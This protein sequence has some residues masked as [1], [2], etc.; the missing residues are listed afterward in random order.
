MDLGEAYPCLVVAVSRGKI[1][2]KIGEK[3][4]E[5]KE[6]SEEKVGVSEAQAKNI[7]KIYQEIS[8]DQKIPGLRNPRIS[9]LEKSLDKKS[10]D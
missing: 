4:M 3:S 10:R 8:R 7:P 2:E 9:I 6:K 1:D 5:F